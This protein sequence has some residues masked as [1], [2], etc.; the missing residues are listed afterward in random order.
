[1]PFGFRRN[2]DTGSDGDI[3]S[4]C[5]DL[6]TAQVMSMLYLSQDHCCY[7]WPNRPVLIISQCCGPSGQEKLSAS[8]K[9][10]S[11]EAAP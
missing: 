10:A 4:K 5:S 2:L 6:Y 7:C 3:A 9:V 8:S 1:M 11:S